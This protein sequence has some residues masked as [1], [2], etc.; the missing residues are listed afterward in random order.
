MA[1]YQLPLSLAIF[2]ALLGKIIN[3]TRDVIERNMN[4]TAKFNNYKGHVI[5]V[6]YRGEETDTLIKC[7]LSDSRRQNGHILLCVKDSTM[8]HPLSDLTDVVFAKVSSFSDANELRRI[9][10][11]AA[12]RVIIH[13]ENDEQTLTASLALSTAVN[14]KCHI[15]AYFDSPANAELLDKHCKNVECGTNRTSSL[16]ARAMQDPGSSRVISQLLNP[17][18]GATQF[19]LQVPV[20][21]SPVSVGHLSGLMRMKNKATLIAVST[22][23]SGD[24]VILNPDDSHKVESG[25]YIH[26]ISANRLMVDEVDWQ[27]T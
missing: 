16:L 7:I 20:L 27:A 12:N 11:H 9:A 14:D 3:Q 6:G 19:S 21:D 10:A 2:G 4:G 18:T 8:T 5:V 26:Y 1:I 17:Q 15:V 24:D 22:L 25:H 23:Q 13:A